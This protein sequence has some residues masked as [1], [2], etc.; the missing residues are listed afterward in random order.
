MVID[1]EVG[2]RGECAGTERWGE[3]EEVGGEDEGWRGEAEGHASCRLV[4]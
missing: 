3:V 1:A 4:L 2:E